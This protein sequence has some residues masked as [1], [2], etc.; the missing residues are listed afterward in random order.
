M[1]QVELEYCKMDIW[2]VNEFNSLNKK[3]EEFTSRSNKNLVHLKTHL[4]LKEKTFEYY[5]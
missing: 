5:F 1:E 4:Y 3:V 2:K